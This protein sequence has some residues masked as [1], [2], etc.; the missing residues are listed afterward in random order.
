MGAFAQTNSQSPFS[1]YGIGDE[2]MSSTTTHAAM[3]HTQIATVSTVVINP[4]NPASMAQIA[5]PVFNFDLRT[6][7]LVLDN[8]LTSQSNTLTSIHNITFAFPILIKQ[9][10]KRNAGMSFGLVPRTQSGYEAFTQTND[11]DLGEVNYTFRGDG[12]LNEMYLGLGFDLIRDSGQ[13]N[14][15]SL[16]IKGE[17]VFGNIQRNRYTTFEATA[18][19]SNLARETEIEISDADF[20]AGITYMR[21][22]YLKDK[23]RTGHFSVGA[24]YQPSSALNGSERNYAYSFVGESTNP[25]IIDTA[26][27][28][29]KSASILYPS[30]F[31]LGFGLSLDNK[32]TF[33]LDLSS[34]SWS[35][36]EVE[37]A[38]QQLNNSSRLSFG[39][40]FIPDHTAYKRLFEVMR[41]RAGFS[42]QQ[43]RL[44]IAGTQ[45]YRYGINVGLGV[46]LFASRSTSILNVAFEYARRE[47]SSVP[48]TESYFNFQVGVSIT[49]NVYDKWFNKRKYD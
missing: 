37:G 35:E 7:N 8:S 34:K 17:Y 39:T 16:G 46:P 44:N 49:P 11:P 24:Y 26:S 33:G 5:R 13:V 20:V 3:G 27:S 45:P 1:I 40:E 23:D 22:L 4:L 21:R 9:N 12:G 10:R 18:N 28:V 36:L 2:P 29:T 41:Y 30:S 15:L 31:G 14:T 47:G 25:S 48:V 19:A 38:N 6:E 43:S 32:W 42:F